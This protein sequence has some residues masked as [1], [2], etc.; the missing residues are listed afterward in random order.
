MLVLKKI[1]YIDKRKTVSWSNESKKI[2]SQL[3]DRLMNIVKPKILRSCAHYKG[4]G[5]LKSAVRVVHK[6]II[7]ADHVAR[8][9]IYHYYQTMS[10]EII[11]NK[12]IDL[13]VTETDLSIVKEYLTLPDLKNTGLGII[14]GGCISPLLGALYL[15]ELDHRMNKL[16]R[17]KRIIAYIRYMDDF[18]ILCKQRWQLKQAIKNMHQELKNLNMTLHPKKKF[19]G[20]TNKS[21]D[22][23]GYE[24]RSGYKLTPSKESYNRLRIRARTLYEQGADKNQLLQY[25]QRWLGWIFGGVSK[26]VSRQGGLEKVKENILNYYKHI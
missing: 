16:I 1:F 24:F 19:I 10:H 7:G 5:G 21:F 20:R 22:F 14:A 26:L 15:S 4:H 23:L 11:L 25:L 17:N 8:F 12:L 3:K 13:G 18:I 6:A 2:L 9:D